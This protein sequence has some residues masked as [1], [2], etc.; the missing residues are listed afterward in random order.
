M[1]C[2]SFYRSGDQLFVSAALALPGR[3]DCIRIATALIHRTARRNNLPTTTRTRAAA[4]S[5]TL[6]VD[7]QFLSE[8]CQGWLVRLGLSMS[9]RNDKDRAKNRNG[10]HQ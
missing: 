6:D 7:S 4:R 1:F 9:H 3:K 8:I 10:W 5:A 2:R